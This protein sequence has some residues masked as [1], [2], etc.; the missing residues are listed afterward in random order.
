MARRKGFSLYGGNIGLEQNLLEESSSG[1]VRF[2]TQADL[3]EQAQVAGRWFI[4]G[5]LP[6]DGTTI[7]YGVPG[8]GKSTV[9]LAWAMALQNGLPLG[10]QSELEGDFPGE[11]I[12]TCWVTFEDGGVCELSQRMGT[13]GDGLDWP[14]VVDGSTIGDL[15]AGRSK[16][17]DSLSPETQR[18]WKGFG[19]QLEAKNVQVLFIDTLSDW[20]STDAS[21]HLVQACLDLLSSLRRDFGVTTVL[22]GHASSHAKEFRKSQ[23]LMGATAWTAK[24]RHTVLV[25]SNTSKTWMRVT[26]S[27]R[28]PIGL[29]VT[30]SK[31]D[32][33]PIHNTAVTLPGEHEAE[34]QKSRQK[35][36]WKKKREQALAA[37]EA[38]RTAWTSEDALGTAAG[39]SKT[40]GKNLVEAGFFRKV[41]RGEYEPVN[42]VIDADWEAWQAS[43]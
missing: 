31:V 6:V 17:Q 5:L 28:G 1:P 16:N 43:Q 40:I 15:I 27:N 34:R 38:G 7:V 19:Q 24:A 36:D 26:K 29:N 23:E 14:R 22:I 11:R 18:L 12:N 3:V 42:E 25:E 9:C 39:G 33:G 20:A 13:F 4:S 41:K 8:D 10:C 2:L 30:M 32:G 35:R 37:R 21:P